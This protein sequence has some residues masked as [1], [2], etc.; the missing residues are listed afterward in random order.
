[1]WPTIWQNFS[2]PKQHREGQTGRQ[3]QQQRL[4]TGTNGPA[5]ITLTTRIKIVFTAI[6]LVIYWNDLLVLDLTLPP[7]NKKSVCPSTVL[8][9]C[10]PLIR[11]WTLTECPLNI[12]QPLQFCQQVP[13]QSAIDRRGSRVRMLIKVFGQV[14]VM[15]CTSRI[16]LWSHSMTTAHTPEEDVHSVDPSPD[17]DRDRVGFNVFIIRQFG[18]ETFQSVTCSGT[19][20]LTRT[21]KRP[22]TSQGIMQHN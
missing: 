6:Y 9:E 12:C 14:C 2:W 22:N 21:T 1:M 15:D 17:R 3:R 5:K 10:T 13:S 20:N 8:L 11:C 7:C 4:S 19:D 16:P 18:D